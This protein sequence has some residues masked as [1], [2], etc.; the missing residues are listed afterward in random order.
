MTKPSVPE[1]RTYVHEK[2]QGTTEVR[3]NSF[4]EMSNPLSDVPQTWCTVCNAFGPVSEFTWADTGEKITD[5]RARHSARATSLERFFCSRAVWFG[6]LAT[7]L[8]AG[9]VGGFFLFAK[10]GWLLKIIM[11]PFTG[12]VCVVLMGAAMIETTKII[13]WRVCGFR[14]PRLLK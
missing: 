14:E 11:I 3:E 9:M 1:S 6:T 4:E 8:I 5:Y 12:F 10:S 7:A 2:C 13:L